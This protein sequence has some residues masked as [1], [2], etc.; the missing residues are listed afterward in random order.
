MSGGT[1]VVNDNLV[2][3]GDVTV[4]GAG[5]TLVALMG[6]VNNSGRALAPER[7]QSWTPR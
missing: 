7:G 6:N 2:N 3:S 1:A 5:V 4:N